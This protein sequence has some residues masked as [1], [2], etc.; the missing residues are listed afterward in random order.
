M[1]TN[2]TAIQTGGLNDR[3]AAPHREDTVPTPRFFKLPPE[4][5]CQI[6]DVAQAEF[7][8]HGFDKASLNHIIIEAN[9]S[10]G[11]F[12]YYFDNKADLFIVVVKR[13]IDRLPPIVQKL[14]DIKDP[15]R[16][17]EIA[18]DV[19]FQFVKMKMDP[20]MFRILGEL[21]DPRIS[22]MVPGH[23]AEMTRF[24]ITTMSRF[25]ETGQ[26]LGLIRTDLPE[27]LLVHMIQ[28]I[29]LAI[30]S[31]L[32]ETMQ[33]GRFV[34][35]EGITR[36]LV[37]F[38]R[39]FLDPGQALPGSLTDFLSPVIDTGEGTKAAPRRPSDLSLWLQW[40]HVGRIDGLLSGGP[41]PEGVSR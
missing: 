35:P 30:S 28:G 29:M 41:A 38:V 17:W 36:F 20:S 39:R 33:E 15:A 1:T 5:Q 31:W 19:F 12:Y 11:A 13:L 16:F 14:Y 32:L 10:K 21:L 3:I 25:L 27:L 26:H 37:E 40:T 24:S 9:L 7:A 8:A 23:L 18:H 22:A 34:D 4:R 6:L 2:Q